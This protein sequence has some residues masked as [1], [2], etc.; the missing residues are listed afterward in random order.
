MNNE[1]S[2]LAEW[3]TFLSIYLPNVDS[4]IA[5]FI[6]LIV[7][8]IEILSRYHDEPR[9]ILKNYATWVYIIINGAASFFVLKIAKIFNLQISILN[10]SDNPCIYAVLIAF[11][12]M[13]IIRSSILN[14]QISGKDISQGMQGNINKLLKWVDRTYDRKRSC[15]ILDDIKEMVKDIPFEVVASDILL[16]CV[17]AMDGISEEERDN[18]LKARDDLNADGRLTSQAKT[19]HLAINIAKITG[20]ALLSKSIDVWKYGVPQKE[21]TQVA[22]EP[23]IAAT[24][25]MKDEIFGTSEA[26]NGKE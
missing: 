8:I 20:I 26:S 4:W 25:R 3:G 7:A 18:L 10:S 17:S 22:E 24:K 15:Y 23:L 19:N 5:L 9:W 12:A 1:A 6:G 16:T 21:T 2:C 13:A 11:S 14:I